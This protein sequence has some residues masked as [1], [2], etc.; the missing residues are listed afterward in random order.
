[1][2]FIKNCKQRSNN[3]II[4]SSSCS[5]ASRSSSDDVQPLDCPDPFL[6]LEAMSFRAVQI[7][8]TCVV[9]FC[10]TWFS[11]SIQASKLPGTGDGEPKN[12]GYF[13]RHSRCCISEDK[14][15]YIQITMPSELQLTYSAGLRIKP[16]MFL[17]EK[18]GLKY[19]LTF[20]NQTR[21][22]YRI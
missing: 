17:R 12:A 21:P 22:Y 3:C 14:L 20:I 2:I 11:S 16:Q 8:S 7:A 18:G 15:A 9:W 4:P 1:M 19:V 10:T 6:L 5:I 13:R